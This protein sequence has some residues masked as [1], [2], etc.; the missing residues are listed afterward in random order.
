MGIP[1][2][3]M[4]LYLFSLNY[5]KAHFDKYRKLKVKNT[6]E[7]NNY[8]WN[9]LR[10]PDSSLLHIV[11]FRQSSSERLQ[12]SGSSTHQG[13]KSKQNNYRIMNIS[14]YL[15]YFFH[16]KVKMKETIFLAALLGPERADD[17]SLQ[18]L[19]KIEYSFIF[20]Y[21]NHHIWQ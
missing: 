3:N 13:R 20:T 16:L 14:L 17:R 12:A 6:Q 5:N 9:V 4:Q 21:I 19:S 8:T 18:L 10:N 15:N 7:K 1:G 2:H 11:S